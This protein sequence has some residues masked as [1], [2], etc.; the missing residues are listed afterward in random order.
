MRPY[1]GN[2]LSDIKNI[3]N[4]RLSRA[5]RTIE[6]TFGILV[7]RWRVLRKP[8]IADINNCEAIVKAT[9]V[10]HNFLQKGEEDLPVSS[11]RYC[12]TGFTDYVDKNGAFHYG[13]WRKEVDSLQHITR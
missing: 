9:I 7:Q 10:L 3:F 5:R 8:F 13:T 4:Y 12:P 2:N 6:N 1:P 11:R